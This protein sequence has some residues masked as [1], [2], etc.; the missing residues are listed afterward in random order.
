LKKHD[1]YTAPEIPQNLY[2]IRVY[3]ANTNQRYYQFPKD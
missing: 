1:D 2:S 3:L